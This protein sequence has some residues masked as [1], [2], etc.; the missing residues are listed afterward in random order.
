MLNS[1]EFEKSFLEWRQQFKS[2]AIAAG[3]MER[4]M[5]LY[6]SHLRQDVRILDKQSSQS[7]F[8][9]TITDYMDRVITDKRVRKGRACFRSNR[10]L[11][12]RISSQYNVDAQIILALW[13]VETDYGRTR[14]D[15]PVLTSLATLAHGGHRADFFKDELIAALKILEAGDTAAAAMVGSWAGAMGHGQFMPSSFQRFAVDNDGDGRRD[16][17]GDDPE[18][19]L[20]SI[21][22]YL[23][24]HGWRTSKPASCEIVLPA[25][26]DHSQSGR[27]NR[28]PVRDWVAQ[29]VLLAEGSPIPDYGRSSVLIPSGASGPAFMVFDNFD[30]L[31]SY[32]RVDSYAIA[33]AHLADRLQGGRPVK[34]RCPTDLKAL[35]RDEMREL[36]DLLTQKGHDAQGAD[37]FSGPNTVRALKS[38]Q[39]AHGLPTDGFGSSA[40]LEHLRSQSA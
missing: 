26:F 40:M 4:T 14:G 29:G 35:S 28:L 1:T 8:I 5:E 25:S 39:K 27:E 15:W 36:Q 16:I 34:A 6:A 38:Y 19:G 10:Q 30:V 2:E 18:D 11:L 22:N 17:W 24:Q 20:A 33:T 21:A 3:V 12:N 9:L 32:N 13:G 23:A 37:G 7:E 31:L